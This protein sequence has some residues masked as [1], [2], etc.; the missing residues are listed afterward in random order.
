MV[1]VDAHETVMVPPPAGTATAPAER[2]RPP[3][4]T[5]AP[6]GSPGSA[7]V[8]GPSLVVRIVPQVKRVRTVSNDSDRTS[9]SRSDRTGWA[10]GVAPYR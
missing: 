6:A 4:L 5:V 2:L 3:E 9:D 8:A 1:A 10:A 7:S